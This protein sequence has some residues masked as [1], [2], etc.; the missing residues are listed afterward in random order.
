MKI[1]NKLQILPLFILILL[2]V[3]SCSQTDKDIGKIPYDFPAVNTIASS[4]EWVLAP[5]IEFLNEAKEKGADSARYIFYVRKCISSEKYTSKLIELSDTIILPNSLIISIP[6]GATAKKGD[7]ILTWWQSGSGLEKAIVVDDSDPSQP[8]VVY[9]DASYDEDGEDQEQLEANSFFVITD[10]WQTGTSVA[11]ASDYYVEQWMVIRVS[12]DKVLAKGWGGSMEV[13][14]K[15][16]CTPI[17]VNMKVAVGDAVQIPYI[18]SYQ[19]GTVTKVDE[20]KGRIWV[21]TEW[22]GEMEIEVVCPGDITTGL[23]LED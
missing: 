16:K 21:E 3:A 7:I 6:K 20:A 9:L 15:S 2:L 11:Y 23:T 22:V 8:V 19:A 1:R 14:E 10:E 5:S 12:G 13:L 4:N 18:G 17:P